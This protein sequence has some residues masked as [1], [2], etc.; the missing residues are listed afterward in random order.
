[1]T[2]ESSA[3][4]GTYTGN[5]GYDSAGNPTTFKGTA[6]AFNANNQQTSN[7]T[8]VYDGNG[9]PTT[10]RGSAFTFDPESRATGVGTTWTA[11]Y[12]ADGLRGWKNVNGTKT[13]YLYDDGEPVVELD[14]SG[15]VQAV[16][17]FAPDGL[18]ARKQ[19]GTWT[20]Y[21]FDQQ[22]NVAQR[23]NAA[24]AVTSSSIYDAYGTE[25]NAVG[26]PNDVFGYNARSGYLFDRETGLYL[27][28]HRYYDPGTGRW[29]N[30]DPVGYRGGINSY[31]Y[32]GQRA[33]NVVD[34]SGFQFVFPTNPG[35][36]PPGTV[37]DPTHGIDPGACQ[38]PNGPVPPEGPPW[39]GRYILPGGQKIDFHP[40]APKNKEGLGDHW[41]VV[42]KD[43]PKHYK[44]GQ[45]P[46]EP[47]ELPGSPEGEVGAGESPG[48]EGP[49]GAPTPLEG[50]A[51]DGFIEIPEIPII[52]FP[53]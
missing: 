24:Q 47:I 11:G 49:E 16:N 42:G 4:N 53:L 33:V 14:A 5:F 30:R 52:E 34:P 51:G 22:G 28:Q 41:H 13:Y 26:T 37:F 38:H 21:T 6:Q 29:V 35:G 15:T 8:F 3:R 39:Y 7:G 2:Q 32:G 17:V 46:K 44:P 40:E 10:Y 19:G 36:L 25:A 43:D 20:Q 50:G 12:R 48:G 1:M 18:V 9:N 27:C 23:L 31:S 45:S